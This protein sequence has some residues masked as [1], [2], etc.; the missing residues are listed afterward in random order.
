MV[1]LNSKKIIEHQQLLEVTL[2]SLDKFVVTIPS[3]SVLLKC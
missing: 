3:R 1:R 2:L